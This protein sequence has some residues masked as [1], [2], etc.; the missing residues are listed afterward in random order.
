MTN[1]DTKISVVLPCYNVGK[2]LVQAVESVRSQTFT[3]WEAIL[4]DDGSTDETSELCDS[5]AEKDLRVKVI[6]TRNGGG[7]SCKE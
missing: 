6:H 2:Y 4:V 7:E 1:S 5:F 3:E